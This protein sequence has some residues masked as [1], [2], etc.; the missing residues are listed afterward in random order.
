MNYK[1]MN[2]KHKY[3]ALRRDCFNFPLLAYRIFDAMLIIM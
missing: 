3:R 2:Y 1:H